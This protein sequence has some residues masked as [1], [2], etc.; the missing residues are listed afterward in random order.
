MVILW[1]TNLSGSWN[2]SLKNTKVV[3]FHCLIYLVYWGGKSRVHNIYNLETEDI[4]ATVKFITINKGQVGTIKLEMEG[5]DFC[6]N[7]RTLFRYPDYEKSKFEPKSTK[8]L[9]FGSQSI[10][11][12]YWG[13]RPTVEIDWISLNVDIES[14]KSDLVDE[15][16]TLEKITKIDVSFTKP[17]E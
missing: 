9:G 14:I 6:S 11:D 12:P 16:P 15:V 10:K 1:C 5:T 3:L 4:R 13:D 2:R 17:A 7:Y 8:L